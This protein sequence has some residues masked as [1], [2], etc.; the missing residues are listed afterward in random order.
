MI[1][2]GAIHYTSIVIIKAAILWRH[3][4]DW[5]TWLCRFIIDIKRTLTIEICQYLDRF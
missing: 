3:F 5:I 4:V 1:I 2:L